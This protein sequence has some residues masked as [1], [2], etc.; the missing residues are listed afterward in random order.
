MGLAQENK[1]APGEAQAL[2]RK[3]VAA[4]RRDG[5]PKTYAEIS[6]RRGPFALRDLY[7]AVY[8]LDGTLRAHTHPDTRK[9]DAQRMYCEQ[10]ADSMICAGASI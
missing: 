1:S 7:V 6:E 2:V 8:A 3:A 5:A 9:I 4:I 10:L